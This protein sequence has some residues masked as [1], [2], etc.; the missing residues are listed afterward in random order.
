MEELSDKLANGGATAQGRLANT[1]WNQVSKESENI[2]E[3]DGDTLSSG[4]LAQAIKSIVKIGQGQAIFGTDSGSIEAHAVSNSNVVKADGLFTG[5]LVRYR[6]NG[7]NATTTPTLNAFATGVKTLVLQDGSAIPAGFFDTDYDAVV[8]YDGTNWVVVEHAPDRIITTGAA[9]SYMRL[10]GNILVQW[11][12]INDDFGVGGANVPYQVSLAK[13][14]AS[15]I[16]YRAFLSV[17]NDW[18]TSGDYQVAN[19]VEVNVGGY[20][21]GV[22][23]FYIMGELYGTFMTVNWLTVGLGA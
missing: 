6:P 1:E 16:T 11:G 7:A 14:Y 4:D 23:D 18:H 8:R 13:D 17:V 9:V 15:V 10:P 22:G 3:N 19:A 12:K 21:R 2:I 5:M 20:L